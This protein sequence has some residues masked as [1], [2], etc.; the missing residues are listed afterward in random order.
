MDS[1]K[2]KALLIVVI[3]LFFAL[4]LGIAAATAQVEVM[5]WVGGVLFLITC[6]LLGR[7][8][9]ILIPAT[10]GMQGGFNFIPGCPAT[11]HIMTVVVAGFT[12]LRIASRQQRLRFRWTGMETA[13]LLVALTIWQAYLRN[14][15]G[16]RI[17]GGDVSGGKPYFIYG[18]AFIAFILIS[19]AEADL[20][21]WRWAAI[22]FILL[23]SADAMINIISG[24]S[25]AFAEVAIRYYSNVSFTASQ[26][27]N[28]ALDVNE[29]RITEFGALGVLF[30]TMASTLWRPVAALDFRKPWRAVIAF[31]AVAATLFGGF[32]SG[33]AR[34]FIDFSMGS[35]LRRKP[36]DVLIVCFIG[37]M[38]LAVFLIAVPTTSLPFS[39]QRVL[40][41]VPG[42]HVRDDI[43]RSGESSNDF[44]F[45]MWKRALTSDKYIHNKWLGDGFQYS[46]SEMAARTAM[47]FKDW[48]MTGGMS[49]EEMFMITGSY[50]GFHVETIRFTGVV[51]LIAATAALIVFAIFAARCIRYYRNQPAWGFVLF[52][53]MPFLIHPLWYWVVFG[54]Y[55]NDFAILIASAGMVKLLYSIHQ[56]ELSTN[57]PSLDPAPLGN[58]F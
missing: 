19:T 21:T 38:L 51:G 9:W 8:I 58:R 5:A 54:E 43:V 44:R 12:L 32:R 14:P 42:V 37:T 11:W 52:V 55:R 17:M 7:H 22:G 35:L 4:Y 47:M 31:G 24:F 16:L 23:T 18:V 33:A 30:G 25:P 28:Y 34:L 53:C 49:T 41:L 57:T 40:T 26:S 56:S 15:T 27:V 10:L 20:R 13:I 29:Q 36:L 3:A 50:H 2:L 6:L 48:R 1:T 46:S 45:D 39:V